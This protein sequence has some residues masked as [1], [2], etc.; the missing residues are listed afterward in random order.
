MKIIEPIQPTA[1]TLT[2]SSIA[3]SSLPVW[4]QSTAYAVDDT[5]RAFSDGAYR[6]YKALIANTGQDPTTGAVD[7]TG[8]SYWLSVGSTERWAMFDGSVNSPTTQSDGSDLTFEYTAASGRRIN[9]LA[10]FNVVGTDVTLEA[11]SV[12][13][14]GTVYSETYSTVGSRGP[15]WWAFMFG[16]VQTN[17]RFQFFDI[18]PYPDIIF[19]V[20]ITP[21]GGVAAIGEAVFGSNFYVGED[22]IGMAPEIK[23]YSINSF[24]DDFGYNVLVRRATRR[25]LKITTQI[26]E[27]RADIVFR[28]IEALASVRCVFISDKYES[29]T[30]YGFYK[31]FAPTHYSHPLIS[32]N[33]TIEGL[34]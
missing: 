16:E 21:R 22:E 27:S 18:P 29:G 4:D 1:A 10:L 32:A 2:A 26:P 3:E 8:A 19:T 17:T 7:G 34:I 28:R 6:I 25:R 12:M 33:F 13:G 31:E 30:I 9:A 14:G 5:V 23:D 20:T 11:T 24:N 15:A